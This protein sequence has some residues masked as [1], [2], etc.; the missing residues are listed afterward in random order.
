MLLERSHRKE[1]E[2]F[3]RKVVDSDSTYSR[4]RIEQFPVLGFYLVIDNP[5]VSSEQL[6]RVG[7]EI[8]GERE[9]LVT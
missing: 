8:G 5:A 2:T 7:S 6:S 1:V 9:K 4:G 3:L